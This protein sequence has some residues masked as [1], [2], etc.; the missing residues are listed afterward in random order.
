MKRSKRL[1]PVDV[2]MNEAE[3]ECA[4]RVAAVQTRL[5]EAEHR[6]QELRRYLG[7]YQ[8]A[9][10]QRAK[11][12]IGAP[13][14]RDYQSFIARLGEAVQQQ[15]GVVSQLRADCEQA[16]TLWRQA[17]VRKNAVG[18]VIAK[19]RSEDLQLEARRV[20]KESDERAVRFGGAR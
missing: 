6:G 11:A 17:A 13:G 8:S 18:K 14:M 10:R 12:G 5:A 2:L 1:E 7:E 9:F 19:A 4:L 3:R 15:D 20:Q 16:R